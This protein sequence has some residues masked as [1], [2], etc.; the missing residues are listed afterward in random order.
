MACSLSIHAITVWE[1]KNLSNAWASVD[2]RHTLLSVDKLPTLPMFFWEQADSEIDEQMS[3]LVGCLLHVRPR[4]DLF[5]ICTRGALHWVSVRQR[6]PYLWRLAN[7]EFNFTWV[8]ES[9]IDWSYDC[10]IL[11]VTFRSSACLLVLSDAGQRLC[12][13]SI[14]CCTGLVDSQNTAVWGT[15][16]GLTE[17]SD[18]YKLQRLRQI[19]NI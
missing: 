7:R 15:N 11:Y 14:Q 9:L 19:Q 6:C 8:V 10:M 16:T 1:Q 5:C 12:A 3:L 2:H 18:H 13:S 17:V 4:V